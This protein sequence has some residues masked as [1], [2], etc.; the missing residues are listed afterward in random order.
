[1]NIYDQIYEAAFNDELQKVAKSYFDL[2][3]KEMEAYD[4]ELDGIEAT[5]TKN[6]KDAHKLKG[7]KYLQTGA[8]IGAGTGAA[9]AVGAVGKILL[10]KGLPKKRVLTE[11]LGNALYG[12]FLGGVI[13]SGVGS[14]LRKGTP[15]DKAE[16]S[17]WEKSDKQTENL[18]KK[19]GLQ[20]FL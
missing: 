9:S 2:P 12:G 10:K 19:Y 14:A 16:R 4:Q 11:S 18:N 17:A 3:Q 13:G 15:F 6:V 20:E 7:G 1:M 5:Y 8:L